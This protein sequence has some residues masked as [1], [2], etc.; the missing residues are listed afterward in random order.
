MFTTKEKRAISDAV[1]FAL[2]STNNP[3]LPET[4]INFLLHVEG[5]EYWSWADILNNGAVVDNEIK[6]NP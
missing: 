6:N 4:E 3:E 5:A 1:Q 2:R